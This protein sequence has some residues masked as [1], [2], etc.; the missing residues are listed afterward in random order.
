MLLQWGRN[1]SVAEGAL[2]AIAPNAKALL[3]W[4]R[5]LSVAEGS[6]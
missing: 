6:K 5:N 4:G 2:S 1:L 3:Q